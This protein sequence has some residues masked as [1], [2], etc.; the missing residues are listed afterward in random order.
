MYCCCQLTDLL[1]APSLVAQ[2]APLVVVSGVSPDMNHP[3]EHAAAAEHLPPGPLDPATPV[4][5]LGRLV[6][7]LRHIL[8]V[9]VRVHPVGGHGRHAVQPLR[10]TAG[11]N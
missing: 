10:G 9:V 7:R 5:G 6:R 11:L 4:H 1:V 8:P 3:V 2:L